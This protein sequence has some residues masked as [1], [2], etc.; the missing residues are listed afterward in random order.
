VLHAAAEKQIAKRK[1]ADR[2]L[3]TGD[4]S[5]Q[6]LGAFC[7]FTIKLPHEVG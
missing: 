2:Y 6:I 7:S 3:F 1:K 4:L 5:A